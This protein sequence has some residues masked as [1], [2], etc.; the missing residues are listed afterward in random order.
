MAVLGV[1][2]GIPPIHSARHGKRQKGVIAD[3][4]GIFA[5]GGDKADAALNLAIV[6]EQSGYNHRARQ[7]IEF[8]IR[9][10]LVF[11]G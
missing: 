3:T 4:V 11:E 7:L 5:L 1:Q 6:A 2:R 8:V 10:I 9:L